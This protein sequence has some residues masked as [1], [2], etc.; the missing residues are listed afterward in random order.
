MARWFDEAKTEAAKGQVDSDLFGDLIEV[1]PSLVEAFTGTV[2][3][4]KRW[5]V[6]PCTVMIFYEAG[7]LKFC[8]SPKF[9]NKVAFG[10]IDD[11][12]HPWDGIEKAIENGKLEWKGR[13]KGG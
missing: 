5:V 12:V 13:S 10:V 3:E 11:P 9:T 2:D 4:S 7:K 1:C 8:L 6:G